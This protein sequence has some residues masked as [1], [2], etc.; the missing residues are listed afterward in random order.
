NFT[1]KA[2]IIWKINGRNYLSFLAMLMNRAPD[3]ESVF[4]DPALRDA[5]QQG[6]RNEAQQHG[7]ISYL[8]VSPAVKFRISGYFSRYRDGMVL[9]TFYH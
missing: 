5:I 2:G 4:I 8:F 9:L 3:V 1:C 6:P 7:E